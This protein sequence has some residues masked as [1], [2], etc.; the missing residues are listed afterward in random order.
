M[1]KILSAILMVA[2]LAGCA[3]DLDSARKIS[4]KGVETGHYL[5]VGGEQIKKDWDNTRYLIEV[6]RYISR[7]SIPHLPEEKITA[8][9]PESD[10]AQKQY[11][12]VSKN[13]ERRL[14][15]FR[16]LARLYGEFNALTQLNGA[17]DFTK[18][19]V[20][21]V[22]ATKAYGKSL[23]KVDFEGV[24]RVSGYLSKREAAWIAGGVGFLQRQNHRANINKANE[25][26]SEALGS[27]ID[28]YK[29]DINHTKS[30]RRNASRSKANLYRTLSHEGLID[31]SAT[32][33]K[34]LVA[35]VGAK[36]ASNL[37]TI[38]KKKPRLKVALR[39]YTELINRDQEY[40]VVEAEDAILRALERLQ[41]AHRALGSEGQASAL[42]TL[43]LEIDHL[44]RS[45][46]T[47]RKKLDRI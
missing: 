9:A 39:G 37:K 5:L 12:R 20:S 22:E 30:I 8:P 24:S 21:L 29:I 25:L 18:S 42:S 23:E 14:Q 32:V 44:S 34:N 36:P 33:S 43:F 47:V 45:I 17:R 10:L 31:E 46:A 19:Y 35:M 27:V 40:A 16:A 41:L 3:T 2:L 26:V 4:A 38:L 6:N 11:A 7:A 1:K 15:V 13:L 28:L